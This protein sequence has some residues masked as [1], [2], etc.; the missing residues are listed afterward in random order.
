MYLAKAL[1]V[2]DKKNDGYVKS[3]AA[4]LRFAPLFLR[5]IS[6]PWRKSLLRDHQE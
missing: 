2:N 1:I 6:R 4:A 5:A 3:P